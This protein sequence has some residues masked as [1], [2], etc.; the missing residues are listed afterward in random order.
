MTT[1]T[2]LMKVRK[3]LGDFI[4]EARMNDR[5]DA[6][7]YEFQ[8][9]PTK[10]VDRINALKGYFDRGAIMMNRQQK[11]E[12]ISRLERLLNHIKELIMPEEE[13]QEIDRGPS[14]WSANTE[15]MG[16]IGSEQGIQ[17]TAQ[18]T[19][20]LLFHPDNKHMILN[21]G[22][23]QYICHNVTE[24]LKHTEK[25]IRDLI[26]TNQRAKRAAARRAKLFKATAA[27]VEKKKAPKRLD[28]E[29]KLIPEP[30]E[31]SSKD[32]PPEGTTKE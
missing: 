14:A 26:E 5:L 28:E 31:P 23:R 11:A 22:C 15:P 30:E 6:L 3:T 24:I 1:A 9:F 4:E 32:L 13:K 21:I 18:Y 27:R 25:E 19:A 10:K 17:A 12:I 16:L 8:N 2:G 7:R 29:P 20:S